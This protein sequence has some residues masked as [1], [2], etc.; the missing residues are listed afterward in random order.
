MN[1]RKEFFVSFRFYDWNLN[2]NHLMAANEEVSIR[3][4]PKPKPKP[5]PKLKPKH[6]G[7]REQS[8]N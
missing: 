8:N 5:K 3:K 4:K 6:G 7:A 1:N 2:K